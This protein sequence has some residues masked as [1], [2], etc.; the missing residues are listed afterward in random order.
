MQDKDIENNK[1]KNSKFDTAMTVGV[2]IIYLTALFMFARYMVKSI[3][4][5]VQRK[6]AKSAKEIQIKPKSNTAI[7]AIDFNKALNN[8]KTFALQNARD[9]Q[10]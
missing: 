3:S 4:E 9:I 6:K 8:A 2:G 5:T 10:K 7:N 1:Q